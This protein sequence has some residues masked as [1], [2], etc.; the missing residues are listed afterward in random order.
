[1]KYIRF[2]ITSIIILFPLKLISLNVEIIDN[3]FDMG[4]YEITRYQNKIAVLGVKEN[5]PGYFGKFGVAVYDNGEWSELPMEIIEGTSK[6]YIL[7]SPSSMINID[8]SGN[9][10]VSGFQMYK[11]SEG[12]WHQYAVDDGDW[13]YRRYEQFVVDKN[14][15]LWVTTTV[16]NKETKAQYSEMYKFDGKEFELVLK[17]DMPF[18][19]TRRSAGVSARGSAIA[20]LPDGR[21]VVQRT[22]D[23]REDDYKNGNTDDI[24]FINQDK[25]YERVK[26]L[27][28]SGEEFN[29][30]N[31]SI[32][33]IYP[34]NNK[35]WFSLSER[36]WGLS[37]EYQ[38]CSGL[39]LYDDSEWKIFDEDNGFEKKVTGNYKPV[40][41][42]CKIDEDYF[43]IGHRE[44]YILDKDYQLKKRSWEDIL[45]NDCKLY[46]SRTLYDGELGIEYLRGLYLH[47]SILTNRAKIGG[48]V[49][50]NSGEIWLQLNIGI[51]VFNKQ[52]I[53]S[54]NGNNIGNNST[55][56]Y[57]NPATN[58]IFIG[59]ELISNKYQ[60]VNNLGET[61]KEGTGM[62]N[63]IDISD[64][65][66]GMYIVRLYNNSKREYENIKFIK[67]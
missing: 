42:M 67:Y 4:F 11:Y 17:F 26:L 6:A 32:S 36:R 31:K 28:P 30:C 54:V 56:I 33:Q 8:S 10:W 23:S 25:S 35:I 52:I 38:C 64:L 24:Y 47:D 59:A 65:P 9:I 34:E 44:L 5:L 21:I 18:S 51:L 19:F 62:N 37:G 50:S 53:T 2:F 61:V 7:G 16:N 15:N 22:I 27:T 39:S 57:P 58:R 14:N 20:A 63:W 3:H 40:Y 1:M 48:M 55:N 60:I 41:R 66:A 12:K 45:N 46:V 43:L 49:T 13:E 29:E